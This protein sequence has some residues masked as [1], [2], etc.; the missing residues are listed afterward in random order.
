MTHGNKKSEVNL[1]VTFIVIFVLLISISLGV[2]FVSKQK[3]NSETITQEVKDKPK[4]TFL[5]HVIKREQESPLLKLD[6]DFCENIEDDFRCIS[7]Q[8][9][10]FK[11]GDKVILLIKIFNLKSIQDNGKYYVNYREIREVHSPDGQL[12]E[13][14]SGEIINEIKETPFEGYLFLPIKNELL[15]SSS[16]STGRY[17]VVIKVIDKNANSIASKIIYF[18]LIP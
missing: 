15:T 12:I 17:E 11:L 14:V 10:K 1:W 13:S 2:Y 16:D 7:K 8:F 3:S 18:D 5:P 9:N 6:I 4:V